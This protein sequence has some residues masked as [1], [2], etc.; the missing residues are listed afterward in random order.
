MTQARE[1]QDRSLACSGA[2]DSQELVRKSVPIGER[3]AAPDSPASAEARQR[4]IR[5]EYNREYMR[6]WRSQAKIEAPKTRTPRKLPS[7]G[8]HG[9]FHKEDD[10]PPQ[11]RGNRVCGF[12]GRLPAVCEVTRLRMT[13]RNASGFRAVRVPYCGHC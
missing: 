1:G 8:K 7:R 5:R 2:G 6:E 12:C 4:V 13:K 10:Q 9:R 3:V 11:K